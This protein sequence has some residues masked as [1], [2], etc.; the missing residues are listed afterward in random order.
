MNMKYN[1]LSIIFGII[2]AVGLGLLAY[3]SFILAIVL[4]FLG[5]DW[6]VCMVGV[7][8]VL[9]ILTLVAAVLARKKIKFTMIVNFVS[10][11]VVLAINIYLLIV[12]IFEQNTGLIA[13]FLG[14]LALAIITALFSVIA[15][16]KNYF[17]ID[18]MP[19]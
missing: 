5:V 13:V 8:G 14:V 3:L 2:F 18:R 19:W 11:L 4:S 15:K 16:K 9:A 10:L 17:V 1:N 12:G 7:F 6:F